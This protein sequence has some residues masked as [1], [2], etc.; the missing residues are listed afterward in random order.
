MCDVAQLL[1]QISLTIAEASRIFGRMNLLRCSVHDGVISRYSVYLLQL[2]RL[3]THKRCSK[4]TL[5]YIMIS[6][7]TTK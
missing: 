2:D 7:C 3:K 4:N 1:L 5:S 6:I